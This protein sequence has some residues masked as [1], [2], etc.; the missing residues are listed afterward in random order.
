MTAHRA[1]TVLT[2]QRP[3]QTAAVLEHLRAE[4]FRQGVVLRFDPEEMRRLWLAC[5]G[6]AEEYPWTLDPHVL[7][8]LIEGQGER[9]AEDEE[10][11]AGVGGD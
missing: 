10:V 9:A 7:R 2:H 8:P 5:E 3:E 11:L 4:A 6:S 1:V